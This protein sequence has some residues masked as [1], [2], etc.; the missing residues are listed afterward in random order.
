MILMIMMIIG[1]A[2]ESYQAINLNML[3][4]HSSLSISYNRKTTAIQ[5]KMWNCE[6]NQNLLNRK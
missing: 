3:I 2:F 4:L 6:E 1:G 5:L